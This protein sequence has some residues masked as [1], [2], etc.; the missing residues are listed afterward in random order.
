MIPD[1]GIVPE[2]LHVRFRSASG[3]VS[4]APG[5]RVTADLDVADYRLPGR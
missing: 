1:T 3:G 4:I 2:Q 5:K